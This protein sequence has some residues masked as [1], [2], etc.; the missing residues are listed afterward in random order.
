VADVLGERVVAEVNHVAP[1]A[2][3]RD[4]TTGR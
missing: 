4:I 3:T 2:K 1:T